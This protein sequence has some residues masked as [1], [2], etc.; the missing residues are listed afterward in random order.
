MKHI[1]IAALILLPAPAMADCADDAELLFACTFNEGRKQVT[2]CLSGDVVSYAFG[3]VDAPPELGLVRH[4][5]D[6]DMRPWN[7]F[8]RY[9]NESFTLDNGGYGYTLR[10]AIDKFA[11]EG[12]SGVEGELWVEKGED[13]LANLSCDPGS[14]KFSGY[15]LPLFKA[16]QAAGQLWNRETGLWE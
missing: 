12:S 13:T 15:P 7:G 6:V 11:P 9:I 16:K 5:T 10:Y 8:G 1:S 3:P 2:T 14:L 4:V